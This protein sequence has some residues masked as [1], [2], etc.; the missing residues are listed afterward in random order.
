MASKSWPTCTRRFR[1]P[2]RPSPGATCPTPGVVPLSTRCSAM[3][4][5]GSTPGFFAPDPALEAREF[6]RRVRGLGPRF[7]RPVACH[8][9]DHAHGHDYLGAPGPARFAGTRRKTFTLG[10]AGPV[11]S[12]KTALVERLCREL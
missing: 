7:R 3:N 4:R 9:G 6:P 1:K 8:K 12:G 5:L 10:V 11:G 2:P